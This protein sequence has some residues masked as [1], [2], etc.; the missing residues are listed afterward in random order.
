MVTK[1]AMIL[2]YMDVL[3]FI[4][5]IFFICVPFVMMVKDRMGVT[6]GLVEGSIR[7]VEIESSF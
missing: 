3:W 2:R 6:E 7:N 1:L 4:G 5:I